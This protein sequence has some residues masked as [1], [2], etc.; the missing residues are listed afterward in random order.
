MTEV[1]GWFDYDPVIQ[2]FNGDL[3]Y[4][5]LHTDRCYVLLRVERRMI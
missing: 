1:D 5:S 2:L 3:L 4:G